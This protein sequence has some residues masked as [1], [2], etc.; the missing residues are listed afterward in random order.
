MLG[1]SIVDPRIHFFD[2]QAS[3]PKSPALPQPQSIE[4]TSNNE[5]TDVVA[6][7]VPDKAE[8]I[9]E[10]EKKQENLFSPIPQNSLPFTPIV[11]TPMVEHD[12]N[13]SLSVDSFKK[14]LTEMKRAVLADSKQL[15]TLQ[16]QMNAL[17]ESN[18]KNRQLMVRF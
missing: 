12:P 11:D 6:S 10:T 1:L 9:A 15:Q 14:E 4:N 7:T 2:R 5:S 16:T 3:S 13:T 18:Q 8:K 17:I